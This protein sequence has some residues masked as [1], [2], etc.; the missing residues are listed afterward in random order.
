MIIGS[1]VGA[2]GR[3]DSDVRMKAVRWNREVDCTGRK[4]E[5][6]VGVR[7]ELKPKLELGHGNRMPV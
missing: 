5:G 2:G 4:E 1:R 7:G 3:V 6:G